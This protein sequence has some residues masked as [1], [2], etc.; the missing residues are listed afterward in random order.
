MSNVLV[1]GS[2][3]GFGLLT[4]QT[5]ARRGH[6]VFA[7]VRDP[8]T[9][10]ELRTAR[11]A[12]HLPITILQLD[13]RDAASVRSCVSAALECGPIDVVVNNAGYAL[14]ASVEEMDDDE[15]L[16]Q[17][18]TNLFG[19][20]RVVRA[21]APAMR[22]QRSGVIV[23][24][25]SVVTWAPLPFFGAYASS[26]AAVSA[27][28]ESLH[29]ELAPFGVRVVLVEPGPYPTT[30]FLTNSVTGRNSTPESAY[31][32]LRASF[33]PALARLVRSAP[34]DPQEV[35]D[36]IYSAVYGN[37]SR[38][39]YVVGS[40]AQRIARMRQG[41]DF[42]TFERYLREILDWHVGAP[43]GTPDAAAVAG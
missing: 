13:V 14:R 29:Y 38:F 35:A 18:D 24:V 10:E 11:D 22:E 4:A 31:A 28:S 37:M 39:R 19:L 30:R 36:T 21:V 3:S 8:A 16:E 7:T 9:A 23:N 41:S 2:S 17:F 32:Q 15:L 34:A 40:S 43:E 27:L 26:K 33:Q 25:S 20:I 5:F 12:E 42:E 1:T 6:C